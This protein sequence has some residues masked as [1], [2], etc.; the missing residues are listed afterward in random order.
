[1][2]LLK[3]IGKRPCSKILW[4]NLMIQSKLLKFFFF[5]KRNVVEDLMRE[6]KAAESKN[7]LD[8]D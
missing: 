2:H 8:Y 4:M 1:M 3:I 5:L 6:Y 7:Y